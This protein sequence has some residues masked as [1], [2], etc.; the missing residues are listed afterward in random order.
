MFLQSVPENICPMEHKDSHLEKFED[1]DALL[2]KTASFVD[3]YFKAQN[4]YANKADFIEYLKNKLAY[5]KICFSQTSTPTYENYTCMEEIAKEYSLIVFYG[6]KNPFIDVI[7]LTK[8]LV[9]K[10]I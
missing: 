6:E 2:E 3:V 8:T 5:Y 9:N 7:D 1:I 4:L 10:N